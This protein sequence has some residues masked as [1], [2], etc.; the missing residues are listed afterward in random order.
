M[1]LPAPISVIGVP[2]VTLAVTQWGWRGGFWVTGALSALYALAFWIWYRNPRE[3]LRAGRLSRAEHERITSGGVQ[4]EDAVAVSATRSLGYLL[5]QRKVWG[6]TL[7]FAAYGY[8]F[9][10]LLTWLPG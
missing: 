2:I 1:G 10:L 7:G 9:Y 4:R 5:R 3:A 6:L 8:S